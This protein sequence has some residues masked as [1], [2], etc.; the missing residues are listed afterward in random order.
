MRLILTLT[1]G[2]SR[3]PE[4]DK[5]RTLSSADAAGTISIGRGTDNVWMLPNPEKTLSRRHCLISFDGR[6]FVLTDLSQ[7]GVT[8]NGSGGPTE[9]DS[10][11]VLND[12]DEFR[13][14]GF[15]FGITVVD[16]GPVLGLGA[17]APGAAGR[18]GGDPFGAPA[19]GMPNQGMP[20]QGM[21][22][23]G[24]PGL[25]GFPHLPRGGAP[26]NAG[27]FSDSPF[28]DPLSQAA[29]PTPFPA[30]A[31]DPPL[32]GRRGADPFASDGVAPM[33]RS[34]PRNSP[35]GADPFGG[36]NEPGWTGGSRSD[37][38][39]PM[40]QAMTP[41]KVRPAGLGGK[42]NFDDLIGDVDALPGVVARQPAQ[43]V[44]QPVFEP[45]RPTPPPLPDLPAPVA[46]PRAFVPEPVDPVPSALET[47]RLPTPAQPLD[48]QPLDTMAVP[49]PV[50]AP[51][52]QAGPAPM[53]Q[54]TPGNAGGM[55]AAAA[56]ALFLEGAGLAPDAAG[57]GKNPE[58]VLRDA[59]KI[60]RA[61]TDGFRQVLQSRAS[62]KG[63]MGIERTMIAGT[64][65]NALKFSVTTDQ[66]VS[67]LLS[68]GSPGYMD[69]V[70]AARE[71][72]ADI[73]AHEL[74][75]MA[76]MQTALVSLLRRF[77]PDELEQR[78]ATGVLGA[79]LPAARKARYWD[80]FRQTHADISR[81]AED[82]FQTVFGRP[83]AKAYTA[84]TRKT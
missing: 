68:P 23:Q 69:P 48:T 2:G 77:D 24:M 79:V 1:E 73:S 28:R 72:A 55:D 57:R 33:F 75:V 6:R 65:N 60:F 12:A 58:D 38:A 62:V 45:A 25:G 17:G 46:P 36:S 29:A 16:D 76:G 32:S 51:A 83:F 81:E 47:M 39:S 49:P 40:S 30:A 71:A 74:A 31:S 84:Q 5:V 43:G 52:V 53:E 44:T 35:L 67:L 14:G 27:P 22:N 80:A 21:P 11:T 42:V 61:M 64:G 13:I 26:R 66:A 15:A 56:L 37:H 8:F 3:L 59:G 70:K 18:P 19:Q 34:E 82:E 4:K 50:E 78:L 20:N 54:A 10:V 41:P 9:R 63:D 7:S